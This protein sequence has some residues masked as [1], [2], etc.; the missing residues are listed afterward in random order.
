M[1][2]S[3][4]VENMKIDTTSSY[5]FLLLF[6]KRWRPVLMVIS[7]LTI[8][9][10]QFISTNAA[11]DIYVNEKLVFSKHVEGRYPSESV[12]LLLLSEVMHRRS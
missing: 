12:H 7:L 9:V 6:I 11:F 10:N 8:L 4:V 3:G 2:V 5:A 1:I